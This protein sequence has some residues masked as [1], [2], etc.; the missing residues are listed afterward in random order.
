LPCFSTM[1]N[2][3]FG[4]IEFLFHGDPQLFHRILNL[5]FPWDVVPV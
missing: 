3:R 4:K 1:L 2:G 5:P